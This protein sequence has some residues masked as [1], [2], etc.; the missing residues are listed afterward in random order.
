MC[1]LAG[2]L[3]LQADKRPEQKRVELMIHQLQHRGPDDYGFYVDHQLALA[4]AR[5]SIIDLESGHQPVHDT[6]KDIWTVFNGEIFNYIELREELIKEGVKFYTQSDTE[7]IV[8]LY[9]KYGLD[10]VNHLN[11]QFAIALWD[12][13]RS[14]LMLIRD[15]VG[16]APL[17]YYNDGQHLY[18]ASEIKAIIPCMKNTPSL[19]AH[20]LDQLLTFWSPVSPATLFENVYEVRPGEITLVEKGRVSHHS[21]WDWQYPVN[22]RENYFQESE[23]DLADELHDKMLDA[24][25]IRLRSDV[26]V[27]AYLSGGLDSSALVSIIHHHGNVPLRTF[28]IGFE[29][30]KLDES[31]YQQQLIEH[32][33]ADHSSLVCAAKDISDSFERTIWHTESTILRTAPTPMMLLS[34]LVHKNN[35]KVVL[36]GEGADEVFGGYDIFKEGK[37]RQFWA[38]NKDSKFRSLLLKR[39]YPY[40]DIAKSNS[41]AYLQAF[42]GSGLDKP[43]VPYFAHIPRWETTARIKAFYSDDMKARLLENATD[44]ILKSLP[45]NISNFHPFNQSQYIEARSLMAGYLL[46][47]QGDRMLMS[48]SVEGRFPFLDHNVIEFANKLHPNLKMKVLNE[49]YLLKKSMRR[50]V[51]DEIINRHK[52]PY[53]APDIP[54]F[55]HQ[56]KPEYVDELL[57][58]SMIKKYG[59]FDPKKVSILQ[60]KIKAGK[61]TG[62][63]DNM[64]FMAIL[65]TQMWRYLFIEN[66]TCHVK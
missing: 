11:G 35:Y 3:N 14:R 46:C 25:K 64:S 56:H 58:E 12:K 6:T 26:P 5:L 42:F 37:I 10:F 19:N 47:S 1:G 13:N 24:T 40:L 32:L 8:H 36:T 31:S 30:K 50:Y 33:G 28:S 51:P 55:F 29:D 7:V 65:S 16:I 57:S 39:L 62:Y 9:K 18:F 41:A 60:R 53:R 61:A 49:K 38:K 22:L 4:H 20:A 17:F 66:F 43:G 52:Q 44:T 48:N 54:A 59:Y 45:D 2:I 27:A 34:G 15:R 23:D 21:Y 63:K